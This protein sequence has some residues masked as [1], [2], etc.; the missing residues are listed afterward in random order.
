MSGSYSAIGRLERCHSRL[1]L[2]ESELLDL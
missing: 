2:H 1:P